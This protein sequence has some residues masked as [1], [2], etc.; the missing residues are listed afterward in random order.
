MVVFFISVFSISISESKKTRRYSN[1][2]RIFMGIWRM[3]C[4]HWRACTRLPPYGT[5]SSCTMECLP[6]YGSLD[7]GPDSEGFQMPVHAHTWASL[8][9]NEVP[10]RYNMLMPSRYWRPEGFGGVDL[11]R[12]DASTH[13]YAR[14]SHEGYAIGVVEAGEHAFA[15]RGKRWTAIPGRIVI[16]NPDDAHDG[17]PATHEGGYSYRMIYVDGATL[18]AAIEEAAG[19]RPATP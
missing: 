14:H 10:V 6:E 7:A 19:R 15:A 2:R 9:S 1:P 13:R 8:R 12:A 18:T 4:S 11:L 5:N 16:V 17:G 3:R